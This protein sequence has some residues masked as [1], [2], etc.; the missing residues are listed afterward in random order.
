MENQLM[1]ESLNERT[2]ESQARMKEKSL[3]DELEHKKTI[4]D[5]GK[6][7]QSMNVILDNTINEL[8]SENNGLHDNIKHLERQYSAKCGEY[9]EL[10]KLNSELREVAKEQGDLRKQYEKDLKM[11]KDRQNVWNEEKHD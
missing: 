9:D 10:E 4:E 3:E 11:L 2:I 8:R 6:Q 5:Y 1:I 7:I